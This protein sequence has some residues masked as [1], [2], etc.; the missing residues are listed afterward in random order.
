MPK[1]NDSVDDMMRTAKAV[2]TATSLM[3]GVAQSLVEGTFKIPNPGPEQT[4]A[5]LNVAGNLLAAPLQ[6]AGDQAGDQ[7]I[8]QGD[9][10]L[11]NASRMAQITANVLGSKIGRL[12]AAKAA[13]AGGLA[14]GVPGA[15]KLASEALRNPQIGKMVGQGATW[16]SKSLNTINENGG[17]KGGLKS[18]EQ[19]IETSYEN[20]GKPGPK[21]E[22]TEPEKGHQSKPPQT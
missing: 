21:S 3:F 10:A 5:L 6:M 1:Q 4:N 11:K 20:A 7:I 13:E 15:G 19:A 8:K 9:N 16:A 2:R 22:T 14:M 18:I 17:V 12:A